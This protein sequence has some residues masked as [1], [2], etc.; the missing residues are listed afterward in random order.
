MRG[1]GR[2]RGRGRP[3]YT[4]EQLDAELDKYKEVCG[5]RLEVVSCIQTTTSPPFLCDIRIG[6]RLLWN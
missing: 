6:S 4:A 1:R 5:Q 3:Q 2:G